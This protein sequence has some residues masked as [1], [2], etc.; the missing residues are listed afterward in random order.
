MDASQKVESEQSADSQS[1][2]TYYLHSRPE[3]LER[4]P[5]EARRILDVGCGGGGLSAAIKARQAAEVHGVEIVS[6]AAEHARAHLDRVWN[7]EIE[8]ALAELPDR[9]YD[10]IVIADVLEHLENPWEILKSLKQKLA[11]GGKLVAS[12][13]NIQNWQ[14]LLNL[15]EGE[16][17][18]KNE[19][20]LDL[21]HLRFFTRKSVE[22]LFW[23]AGF[24]ITNISSSEYGPP[25]PPALLSTLRKLNIKESSLRRDGQTFQFLI[26]ATLPT[27]KKSEPKV[28]IVVLNWNGKDDTLQCIAS[29]KKLNYPNFDII[30]TDNGSTDG[31]LEAIEAAFPDVSTLQTGRNLGYAGGNNRG[32]QKAI[33]AG[34]DYILVL[35]NDTFVDEEILQNL[36]NSTHYLPKKSIISPKIFFHNEPEKIWFAGS[37]WKDETCTFEHV[38]HSELDSPAFCKTT[39]ISYASGCALFAPASAFEEIGLFDEKFFLTYEE[40][41]WCYRAREKGYRCILVPEAKLFHKV[42]ASFG[43]ANSPLVEY[44]MTRNRLLWAK[45]HTPKVTQRRLRTESFRYIAREIIPRL[46]IPN[47][48][49]PYS[50]RLLW[51]LTTWS[52]SLKRNIQEPR[53]KSHLLA[54]RDYYLSRTGDSP[55]SVRSL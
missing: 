52:K 30:V 26:E 11:T 18:Y 45:K 47:S 53:K 2:G 50:K 27:D 13:P 8:K 41:D 12:I 14:I 16:W 7:C 19:G 21:T 17:A 22:E 4:V 43:G 39:E 29:L 35:N 25:P 5:L 15:I 42:S 1:P 10:C 9:H 33:S 40:T 24:S 6:A 23:T 48:T 54:I 36:I 49:L 37:A 44:F 32:I 3:V 28:S 55:D 51:A 20:I 38:G 31:S 34:T 46:Q